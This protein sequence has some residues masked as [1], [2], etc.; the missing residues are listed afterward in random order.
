M[1]RGECGQAGHLVVGEH[2]AGGVGR[3]AHTDGADFLID[4]EAVEI[5]PVLE[6][7]LVQDLD[8]RLHGH[9]QVGLDTQIGVA[10]VLGGQRQEDLPPGAS[11]RPAGKE[12]EQE[13]EGPLAAVGQ[14]DVVLTEV[15]TVLPPQERGQGAAEVAVA[16]GRVVDADQPAQG[17]FVVDDSLQAG[18]HHLLDGRDVAGVAA[19]HH[20]QIA[21]GHGL[22]EVVHQAE[23]ARA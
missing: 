20:D 18:A 5:H 11:G 12:V 9:E 21:I 2:V 4:F 23:D 16:A 17:L 15:P 19:A 13:E 22:A 6:E 3:P 14:A 1:R 10:D 7:G 8:A